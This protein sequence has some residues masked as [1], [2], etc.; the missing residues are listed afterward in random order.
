[1]PTWNAAQYLKFNDERTQPCRDLVA[2]IALNE[3]KRIIDLGCGPGN[4]TSVLASRWPQAHIT[5]LD[6]SA[7]MID[8][9]RGTFPKIHWLEGDLAAWTAAEPMDLVFS[10]AALQ[11]APHHERVAS[12]LFKQ[13]APG[14]ALAWQ[15]PANI[16]AP[17]HQ[18]MRDIASRPLIDEGVHDVAKIPEAVPVMFANLRLIERDAGIELIFK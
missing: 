7:E 14:G 13:V 18:L 10:N 2:R 17:A 4:S 9:A 15:V 11:W 16:N 12:H 1:M 5:G 6:R 8:A 3:P